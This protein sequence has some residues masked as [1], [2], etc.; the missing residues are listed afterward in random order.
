M[1]VGVVR[2]PKSYRN[3]RDMPWVTAPDNVLFAKPKTKAALTEALTGF[4]EAG[5]DRLV[6]D[7]G[8]G[9]VRDVLTRLPATFGA[10]IPLLAVTPS[11]KTNVLAEDLGV[12]PDW[13]VEAAVGRILDPAAPRQV[14]PCIDVV[15]EDGSL[16]RGFVFGTGAYVRATRLAQSAHR[17]G[18]FGTASVALTLAMSVV[19]SIAGRDDR[20]W[21]AGEVMQLARGGKTEARARFL[22]IASTLERLPL[23]L[24]PFGAK[25]PGL[26]SLTID[27]PPRLLLAALGPL[28]RGTEPAWLARAGYVR[29]EGNFTVA[30][31]GEFVLDGEAY[32][33]GELTVSAG[34]A[35]EFVT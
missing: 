7:G 31:D 23:G 12:A 34:P 25:R 18:A 5:V 11:G 27:A 22:V 21:R 16:R 3:R 30:L 10:R 6:L 29:G 33:G 28:W 17:M 9:T 35:L 4:A 24:K 2:N 13:S 19:Q 26:K 15:R 32:P 8:D 20:G 1:R 14:R